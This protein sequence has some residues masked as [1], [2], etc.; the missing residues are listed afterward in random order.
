MYISLQIAIN[1]LFSG[2]TAVPRYC[3]D[4]YPIYGHETFEI[5]I[6]SV[7]VTQFIYI[8]IYIYIYI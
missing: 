8:Y 7:I 3:L 4:A 5:H 1:T 6:N 2:P